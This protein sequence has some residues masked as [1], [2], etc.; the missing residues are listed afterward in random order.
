MLGSSGSSKV[1]SP[2]GQVVS[3]R[4]SRNLATIGA[5]VWSVHACDNA[6]VQ[7]QDAGKSARRR[8]ERCHRQLINACP[9]SVA[10]PRAHTQTS[11]GTCWRISGAES[12]QCC[13]SRGWLSWSGGMVQGGGLT[14]GSCPTGTE[15]LTCRCCRAAVHALR[16]VQKLPGLVARR[17]WPCCHLPH[18]CCC[19]CLLVIQVQPA[20]GSLRKDLQQRAPPVAA[21]A[22][23]APRRQYGVPC[24]RLWFQFEG[25]KAGGIDLRC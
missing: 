9:E 12:L 18:H 11:T 15:H 7:Q 13:L 2:S 21:A 23:P 16:Q 14:T 4:P 5:T 19:C 17:P 22:Q 10:A 20:A 24:D 3:W 25:R 8:K 1:F 6:A